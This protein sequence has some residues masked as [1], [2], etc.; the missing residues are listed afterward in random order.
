MASYIVRTPLRHGRGSEPTPPGETVVLDQA[1]GD[2]LVS[3]GALE[4]VPDD[5]EPAQKPLARM[6]RAE[7][8]AAAGAAGVEIAPGM[9]NKQVVA[10]IEAKAAAGTA[11]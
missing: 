11:E 6:N 8:T 4:P 10:A 9:T 7:L 5:A 1:E 2:A 3:L